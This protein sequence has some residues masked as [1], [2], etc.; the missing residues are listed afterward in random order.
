MFNSKYKLFAAGLMTAVLMSACTGSGNNGENT[1]TPPAPPAQPAAVDQAKPEA[2]DQ[3]KPEAGEQAKP[4]AGDQAKTSDPEK[5]EQ[6]AEPAADAEKVQVSGQPDLTFKFGSHEAK[7][8][9][10]KKEEASDEFGIRRYFKATGNA[11]YFFRE[12]PKVA[13]ARKTDKKLKSVYNLHKRPYSDRSFG[14]VE[15]IDEGVDPYFLTTNG[16]DVYYI[17]RPKTPA[18]YD[19]SKKH[20]GQDYKTATNHPTY[21]N[22]I[23]SDIFYDYGGQVFKANIKE[24]GSIENE[25]LFLNTE[26]SPELKDNGGFGLVYADPYNVFINVYKKAGDKDVQF[27]YEFNNAGQFERSYEGLTDHQYDWAVT[28]N[29]VIA[30]GTGVIKIYDRSNGKLIEEVKTELS[31]SVLAPISGDEVMFYDNRAKKVYRMSL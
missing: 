11:I 4:E 7:V 16:K 19:G 23:S 3:A 30:A 2:G 10:M 8:Y 28:K 18:Y 20:H 31:P 21:A 26:E 14:E 15:L 6:K 9:E 12:D 5:A 25:T 22:G 13:E 27:C 17:V 29:Y 1:Q 24:D